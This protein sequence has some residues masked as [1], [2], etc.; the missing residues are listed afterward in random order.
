[1]SSDPQHW[2]KWIQYCYQL[3][4]P[5]PT[6]LFSKIQPE[7]AANR[8]DVLA[9]TSHIS[10]SRY[11]YDGIQGAALGYHRKVNLVNIRAYPPVLWIRIRN[12][13]NVLAESE[14]EK[15]F[16]FG[17]GFGFRNCC[18]MNIFVKNQKSNTWKRKI[19]CFS[20]YIFFLWRNVEV[21]EHIWKQLE[22]PFRK[23]WGQNISL[24]IRTR[25]RIRKK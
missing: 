6:S 2:D 9:L 24:R 15:K 5:L 12:N 16:G 7:T 10:C 14:S 4:D 20:I 18:R 11:Y 1:M 13:P 19:L 17:Y 22:A 25:I 21:S 3:W 23:I 8:T